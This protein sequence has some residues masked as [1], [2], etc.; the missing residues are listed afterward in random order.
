MRSAY[1]SERD[2]ELWIQ[3]LEAKYEGKGSPFGREQWDSIL[4]HRK[5]LS[6]A[7]EFDGKYPRPRLS[8]TSLVRSLPQSWLRRIPRLESY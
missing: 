7:C 5:V 1:A 3:A 4:G 8:P 2:V 6:P